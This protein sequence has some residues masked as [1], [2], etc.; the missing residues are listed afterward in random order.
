[1]AAVLL[2]LLALGIIIV[3]AVVKGFVLSTMW[4]WFIVPLG[5]PDIG[6]AWAIGITGVVGLLTYDATLNRDSNEGLGYAFGGAVVVPLV[7]LFFG[8]IVHL[9]M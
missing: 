1:M 8:W 5:V 7:T 2:I 9:L 4:G 3:G 6:I